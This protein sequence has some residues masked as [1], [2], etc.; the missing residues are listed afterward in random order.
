MVANTGA[1]AGCVSRF[2][3]FDMV[4][5]LYEWVAD[6]VPLSTTCIGALYGG[7]ENCIGGASTTFG[8]G[9]LIRGGRFGT[10]AS[11]GPF[12]VNGGNQPSS[13]NNIIGFRGA[14]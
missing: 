11:A 2:G 10:G 3:A 8:P 9:A 12:A 1:N 14:R 4:G 13:S 6:W 5:N 7:D